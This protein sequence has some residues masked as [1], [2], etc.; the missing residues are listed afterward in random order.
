MAHP[1]ML[2]KSKSS[3]VLEPDVL[4]ETSTEEIYREPRRADRDP[5]PC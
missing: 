3:A 1:V 5:G 2:S 4:K